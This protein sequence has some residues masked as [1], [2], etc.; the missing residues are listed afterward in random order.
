MIDE[1]C[2]EAGKVRS[3]VC[4]CHFNKM[5]TVFFILFILFLVTYFV[6]DAIRNLWL[7]AWS[8]NVNNDAISLSVRLGVFVGL[9]VF[10]MLFLYMS[11]AFLVFGKVSSSLKLH[12]LLLSNTLRAPVTPTEIT[13]FFKVCF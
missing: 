13:R 2:V 7:S 9:G 3:K 11:S 10:G 12:D 6:L 5:G 8:D 1:E 4:L